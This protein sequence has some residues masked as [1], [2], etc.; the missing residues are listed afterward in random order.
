[1]TEKK[2]IRERETTGAVDKFGKPYFDLPSYLNDHTIEQSTD[3][4]DRTGIPLLEKTIMNNFNT[5]YL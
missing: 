5:T 4:L 1:M 2:N 3:L